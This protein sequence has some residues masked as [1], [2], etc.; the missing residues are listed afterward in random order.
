MNSQ[1]DAKNA[2]E[3]AT[4]PVEPRN[5]ALV[6]DRHRLGFFLIR[7]VPHPLRD[8]SVNIAVV[9]VGDGFADVRFVR[10]WQRVLALDPGADIGLMKGLAREI[11]DKL[12]AGEQ[13]E[14]MLLVMEDSFSNAIQLSP[15]KGCLTE[16]PAIE[17]EA[18]ASQYL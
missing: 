11:R 13:R 7:Y 14:Q 2:G 17:I 4:Q 1:T 3:E 10:D 8:E 16:D 6:T 18:L 12:H 9:M 5:L 15:R